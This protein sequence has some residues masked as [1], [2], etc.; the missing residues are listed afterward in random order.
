MDFDKNVACFD[1]KLIPYFDRIKQCDWLSMSNY[2]NSSLIRRDFLSNFTYK[3]YHIRLYH[4]G[5]TL[6]CTTS[7]VNSYKRS[8]RIS[9]TNFCRWKKSQ[10]FVDEKKLP[11]VLFFIDNFLEFIDKFYFSS[12]NIFFFIDNCFFSSTM[13][14]FRRQTKDHLE[15]SSSGLHYVFFQRI[16][17]NWEPRMIK[18]SQTDG[19]KTGYN[20][21]GFS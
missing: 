19:T 14:F 3:G 10:K 1:Q 9:S 2:R 16:G 15:Y 8:L 4:L 11:W 17:L 13:T 18:I 20:I 21:E 6:D 5:T 7:H 12:T